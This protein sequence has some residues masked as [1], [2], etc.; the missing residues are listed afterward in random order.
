MNERFFILCKTHG[1]TVS[2]VRDLTH[3]EAE[4]V[5]HRLMGWDRPQQSGLRIIND[6]DI[7]QVDI[8][9]HSPNT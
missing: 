5:R 9:R 1:G 8:Y 2:I 4:N 6:G 7:T 3:E